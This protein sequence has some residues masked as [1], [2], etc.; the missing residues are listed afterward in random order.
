MVILTSIVILE[1]MEFEIKQ[2]FLAFSTTRI[3]RSL[4]D[5]SVIT[6]SGNNKTSLTT[7]LPSTFSKIH[8]ESQLKL[9]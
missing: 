5:A 2:A 3:I 7:N 1:V 8:F 4:F 9:T 6:T